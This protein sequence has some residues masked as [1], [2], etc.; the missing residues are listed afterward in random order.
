VKGGHRERDADDCLALRS[1]TGV[2]VHWLAGERIP[3]GDVHGTGCALSAA[4]AARLARG[5]ALRT[6]VE[7]ARVFVRA[8][9][10]NAQAI[11]GGRRVLGFSA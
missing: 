2:E 4:I 7:A 9:I 10:E 5:D 8:A 6:A 1:A 11:G 3:G